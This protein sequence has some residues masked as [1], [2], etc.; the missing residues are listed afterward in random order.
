MK[1]YL[2]LED[3]DLGYHCQ[4]IFDDEN[5]AKLQMERLLEAQASLKFFNRERPEDWKNSSKLYI[6]EFNL[7]D[8]SMIEEE[9]NWR[10][11]LIEN[12]YKPRIQQ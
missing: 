12:V 5:Q 8:V 10:T 7:N 1:L 2:I 3:V 6:E 4:G 11:N 9:I